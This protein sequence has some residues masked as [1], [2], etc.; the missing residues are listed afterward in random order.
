[1]LNSLAISNLFEGAPEIGKGYK[2]FKKSIS[3][4]S[5]R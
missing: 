5:Q 3:T 1:M 4:Y 2:D